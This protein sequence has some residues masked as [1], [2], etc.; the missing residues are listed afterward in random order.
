MPTSRLGFSKLIHTSDIHY[1]SDLGTLLGSWCL[2]SCAPFIVVQL[3]VCMR[4]FL[5][6]S[7]MLFPG[8]LRICCWGGTHMVFW[9]SYD[10][11]SALNLDLWEGFALDAFRAQLVH[12]Q[13]FAAIFEQLMDF[14]FVWLR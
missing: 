1:M 2:V 3:Y 9:A 10:A 12:K 13:V 11:G 5:V 8:V 14:V 7:G 4:C 6:I